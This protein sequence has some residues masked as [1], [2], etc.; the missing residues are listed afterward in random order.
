M[1]TVNTLGRKL[2]Q[3]CIFPSRHTAK[4][5]KNDHFLGP[6]LQKQG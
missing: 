4:K 6:F 2:E 5:M 3:K 1:V